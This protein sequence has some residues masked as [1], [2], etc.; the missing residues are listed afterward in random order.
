MIKD[1]VIIE[2]N[3]NIAAVAIWKNADRIYKNVLLADF[4]SQLQYWY[5]IRFGKN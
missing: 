4:A 3:M 5:G 2:K 1:T